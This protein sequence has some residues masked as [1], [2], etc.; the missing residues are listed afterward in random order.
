MTETV[1][2]SNLRPFRKSTKATRW[3][4]DEEIDYCRR[5]HGYAQQS[6]RARL[7]T[8]GARFPWIKGRVDKALGTLGLPAAK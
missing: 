3:I 4:V 6:S 1:A 5:A 2:H 7:E 8:W